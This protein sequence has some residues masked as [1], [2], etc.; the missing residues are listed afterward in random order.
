MVPQHRALRIVKIVFVAFGLFLFVVLHLM[1]AHHPAGV[2]KLTHKMIA[3]LALADVVLGIVF[4]RYFMNAPIRPEAHGT[5]ATVAQ[6]FFTAHIIR[7]AFT[8]STCLL[9][10]VVHSL[11][12][13]RWLGRTLVGVGVLFMMIMK[14]GKSA[15]EPVGGIQEPVASSS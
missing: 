5:A 7:L 4:Q 12:A 1:D 10:V 14:T 3:A 11:G 6:R 9:G 15:E 8:L 13:P 2:L